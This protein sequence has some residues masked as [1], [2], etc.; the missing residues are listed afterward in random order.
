[1]FIKWLNKKYPSF[2]AN[3]SDENFVEPSYE[4]SPSHIIGSGTEA[5]VYKTSNPDIVLRLEEKIHNRSIGSCEKVMMRPEIQ[6][7]GGVAKIYGEKKIN[8]KNATFKER[9]DPEWMD[10]IENKYSRMIS[11][12]IFNTIQSF[13][14]YT[15][16]EFKQKLYFLKGFEETMNLADAI[17]KGL[18]VDDLHASNLGLNK[19]GHIVAIDC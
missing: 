12:R 17:E 7:T 19:K 18:P 9:V 1:M 6:A 16:D 5:N 15:G 2:I 13:D 14:L 4:L 8:G 3:E 11:I 10:Y